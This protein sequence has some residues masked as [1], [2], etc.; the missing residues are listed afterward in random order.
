MIGRR[1]SWLTESRGGIEI[2]QQLLNFIPTKPNDIYT[3][4]NGY[5]AILAAISNIHFA[6]YYIIN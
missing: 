1:G 2:G 3:W 6:N 4:D 5:F